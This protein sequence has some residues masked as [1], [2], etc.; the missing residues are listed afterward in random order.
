MK[1]LE[2]VMN[3]TH[4][5]FFI[6]LS[7]KFSVFRYDFDGTW[8]AHWFVL[9]T[10]RWKLLPWDISSWLHLEVASETELLISI[11]SNID[12]LRAF[13]ISHRHFPEPRRTDLTCATYTQ[14]L[15]E[16]RRR[17]IKLMNTKQVF[18]QG[19]NITRQSVIW[20]KPPCQN[21]VFLDRHRQTAVSPI[22]RIK[23]SVQ[24]RHEPVVN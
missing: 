6:C 22:G 13:S 11:S 16:K 1:E 12:E 21:K 5:F 2:H 18:Y 14:H 7:R 9:N 17:Q 23:N 24:R 3:S 20:A 19:E 8:Y 10:K 15:V 4:C